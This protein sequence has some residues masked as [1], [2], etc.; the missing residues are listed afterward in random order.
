MSLIPNASSYRLANARLHS[1]LTPGLSAPVDAGGFVLADIAVADGRMSRID[2]GQAPAPPDAIDLAGRIVLPCF[3]DCHTHIDK[4]HIWPRQPNPDGTFLGAL[5]AADADRTA[6]WTAKD[7]ARRMDFSLRCAYAHGTA[8]LR[9][10]IDSIPPQEDI[11][12]PVFE[13]MREQ[14]RGRIELQASCLF[15]IERVG[16][17]D[18]FDGLVR[19]VARAGG[20]LGAVTY[21]A[22]DLDALLD[23]MFRAAIENGLDLDFHADE[24]DALEAVSL[25][26]IAE[27]ALRH[28][29]EGRILVGHCCSLARQP[30]DEV[31]ATLDKVAQA[32]LSVVSLPLCNLYLQ[33]RRGDGTTP[34]WRGVTLL[35]EMK[36]R[37]IP[38]CVASDNTRDPFYAYGDLDMLE[39][40]RE[41]TRIGHLDHPVHDWPKTVAST[42]ASIM[43]LQNP[44][45]LQAGGSADFIVFR[46]RNWTELLSR[47]ES[48]RIVVRG[49]RA[50]ER[51]VPDYA[52]LDDLMV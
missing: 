39:V 6:R 24:T 38:V 42:P 10:H 25:R 4:G 3:V 50:V 20:V 41:A 43:R 9:T 18:W 15:G 28:R 19:R 2:A 27:A 52:E 7:V 29:F 35:H 12:W 1:S 32:G 36:M 45:T 31:K 13:Q 33:D 49:G 8:A 44:G 34:R 47:P 37:G 14:W 22:P 23:T 51:I 26:M 48:D 46:G 40:F 21:M 30:D 5:D 17:K 16:Q 11:S